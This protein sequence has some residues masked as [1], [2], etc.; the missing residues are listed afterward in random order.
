M[1]FLASMILTSLMALSPVAAQ[2]AADGESGT[3]ATLQRD[4]PSFA[5]PT[6]RHTKPEDGTIG[7]IRF[8]T[9]TDFPPFNYMGP[10][11]RLRGLHVDLAGAIC[12]EL[13]VPCTI[14][15]ARW[16][17]LENLLETRKADAVLAGWGP[18]TGTGD[19]VRFSD[20]YL[21]LPAR[22]AVLRQSDLKLADPERL[23]GKLV[24]V[25]ADSRHDTF[26]TDYFASVVI[27]RFKTAEQA[28]QSLKDGDLDALFGDGVH[29]A[30]WINGQGEEACCRF[31]DGAFVEPGYFGAGM[32]IGVRADNDR[33]LAAL[34]YALQ[35][36]DE[37]GDFYSLYLR[38]FPISIY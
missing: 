6:V 22:F 11:K 38:S 25:V 2:Q 9:T 16:D 33:L 28:T 24:G 19:G 3:A 32:A 35:H 29:L 18:D 10:D 23:A 37:K 21:K 31:L 26:L 12:M 7:G 5:D 34:N 14:R 27:K 17:E 4:F 8:V 15:S 36:L 30:F 13:L 1:A 20:I